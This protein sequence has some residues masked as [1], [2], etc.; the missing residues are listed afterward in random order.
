MKN[1]QWFLTASLAAVIA[2]T[3]LSVIASAD[4]G[5]M[6][7]DKPMQQNRE[8]VKAAIASGDY[9][10]FAEV[11]P[12]QMLEKITADN[13]GRFQEMHQHLEAAAEIADELGLKD[14]KKGQFKNMKGKMKGNMQRRGMNEDV[15]N[16]IASGDY[17]AFAAVAPDKMLEH[18][19]TD[20]FGQLVEF[21]NAIENKDFETAKEIQE[22]LG[23]PGP[24]G[25]GQKGIR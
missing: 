9:N 22:E 24:K 20:N 12:E 25:Q 16:A 3:S 2:F 8:E 10:A 4:E 19:N 18:I 5:E 6:P 23:M 1:S 7:A 14:M 21:H 15:R 11:A 17:E 13:F